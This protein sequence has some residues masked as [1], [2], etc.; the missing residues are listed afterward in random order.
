MVSV[1][2]V[3]IRGRQRR[4]RRQAFR[5]V[6]R[7]L[8]KVL[9]VHRFASRDDLASLLPA[10]LPAEFTT[11]DMAAAAGV[12]R[13]VAQRMA[14]CMRSLELIAEVG[15]TKA[16]VHYTLAQARARDSRRGR[17][18]GIGLEVGNSPTGQADDL[19]SKALEEHRIILP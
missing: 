19:A 11:A 15:R 17:V 1:T 2:R 3:Q 9:E 16:G 10:G 18:S 5:T 8:R 6:D 12:G 13:D 14:F 7:E 4:R